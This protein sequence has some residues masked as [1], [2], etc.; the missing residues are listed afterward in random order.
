MQRKCYKLVTPAIPVTWDNANSGCKSLG[1]E[2]ASIESQCEQNTVFEVANKA[3]AWI[4]GND[5]DSEGTFT[6]P[7]GTEFYKSGAAVAGVYTN[8]ASGFNSASQ[9]TQHCVQIQDSD[10]E[11][12]DVVCSKT[13][14]YVCEKEAYAGA[15]TFIQTTIDTTP[16][17][18]C[19]LFTI[20][21]HKWVMNKILERYESM[22]SFNIILTTQG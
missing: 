2:L 7:S 8:L 13:L 21:T 15:A 14:N 18:N 4:G 11:W 6:W 16:L 22:G 9:T 20:L 17:G 3:A 1:S 19:L 5:K 12:D 10:G